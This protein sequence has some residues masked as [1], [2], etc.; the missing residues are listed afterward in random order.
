[1]DEK[2]LAALVRAAAALNQST[3]RGKAKPKR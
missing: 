1:V 2:A 3:G